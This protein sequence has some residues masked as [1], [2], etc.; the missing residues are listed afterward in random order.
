V[1][2]LDMIVVGYL[3]IVNLWGFISM[4]L[5]KQKA[6]KHQYRTPEKHLWFI[7][8][9]GGVFGSLIGMKTQHHKTRTNIFRFGMPILCVGHVLLWGFIF[10]H[11]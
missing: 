11:L 4:A 5:D 1:P 8:W 10:L 3:I 7:A 6:I 9:I 2:N